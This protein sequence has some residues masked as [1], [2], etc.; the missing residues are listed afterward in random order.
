[1][2]CAVNRLTEKQRECLRLVWRHYDSKKIARELGILP[3]AVDGRI[4][5]ATKTLGVSDRFEAARML[6]QAEA[7]NNVR[8]AVYPPSYV[9]N[10]PAHASTMTPLKS[11]ERQA[12]HLAVEEAQAPYRL[13]PFSEARW[14]APPFPVT[15]RRH[16]DLSAGT[17][18]IWVAAI[19]IGSALA[20]GALAAGIEALSRLA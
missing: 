18:L 14:I 8:S 7:G 6:V 16:N 19:A 12:D 11:G 20:F 2:P 9:P 4:K 15:G 13:S 1:M 5:T 17:R 10:E 3:D